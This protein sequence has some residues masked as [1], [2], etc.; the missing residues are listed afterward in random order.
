MN[1]S[2]FIIIIKNYFLKGK[3]TLWKADNIL[4]N[5]QLNAMQPVMF[6]QSHVRH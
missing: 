4:K 6:L 5:V 1:L 3:Y 2:S